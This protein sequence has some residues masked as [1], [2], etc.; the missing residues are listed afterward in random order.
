MLALLYH[1]TPY[2]AIP[3]LSITICA[4]KSG[5]LLGIA[6]LEV[7]HLNVPARELKT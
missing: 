4:H 5:V 2:C 3:Y 1:S 6:L 7:C